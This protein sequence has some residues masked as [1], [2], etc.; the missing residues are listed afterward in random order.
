MLLR[1]RL[2]LLKQDVPPSAITRVLTLLRPARPAR[3]GTSELCVDLVQ[4][5][6]G[7]LV[8]L[9]VAPV[10]QAVHVQRRADPMGLQE[11]I[12]LYEIP[13]PPLAACGS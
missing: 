13:P 12:A 9:P 11:L 2:A 8:A 1:S 6:S 4:W 10:R 5:L 7:E 3:S